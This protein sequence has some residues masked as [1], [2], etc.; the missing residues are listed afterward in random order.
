MIA[1]QLHYKSLLDL[2]R[3]IRE[4]EVTSLEATKA[5]LNRIGKLDG[6]LH[7]YAMVLTERAQ[8]QAEKLDNER[9]SGIWRGPLHGVPIAVKDLCYTHFAPTT[10]GTKI[11]AKFVPSYNATV[12]DRLERAGAVI[13]GKLKM[14]EGAYTSH[15]PDDEGP[16][17][18]WNADYWV[19]SSSTGSGAATAAGLCYGSIGTDTGGSI[20]LPSATCGL[21]GI[22]PTWGRVSRY[23]IF[24][25]GDSLDH[26][27][28]MCR[29]AADAAAMLGVIAGADPKD[30]TALRDN[31]PNYL[32]GIGDGVRGLR[33]GIDRSYTQDGV[34]AQIV[35]A[36]TEA[37]R[38]FV[39]AGAEIREVRFPPYKQLVS[40]WIP[41]CSVETAVAHASTY[42]ARKKE[43]G[44]ALAALIEQGRSTSGMDVAAIL[45]ERLKFSGSLK[46]LFDQVDL[47]LIPTLPMLVPTLAKM[48]EYGADPNVLLSIIRFTA[49]FDFSGNPTI[50]LPMGMATD[51]MPITMQLVGRHVSEDLLVRAAH[52]FQSTTDWHTRR[53]PLN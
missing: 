37:E 6:R 52:A 35:A 36:L 40:M 29:T 10:A 38:V 46:S 12:V 14:T 39:D 15:H 31:V 11:H 49:V 19:G 25:L 53:P 3:L 16:I 24:A 34:D 32:R 4:G 47:L 18:P 17:N 43:Y 28:P 48:S 9:C 1:D 30:P 22:K 23:G 13:L 2:S 20:R 50:T 5:M 21:T 41:M 8:E 45:H 7:A 44:P 26:V 42:P 27:G 33:I 51:R